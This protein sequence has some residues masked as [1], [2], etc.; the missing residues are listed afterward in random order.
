MKFNSPKVCNII[1]SDGSIAIQ[2]FTPS[3]FTSLTNGRSIFTSC[4]VWHNAWDSQRLQGDATTESQEK[5]A[6]WSGLDGEVLACFG[7]L[8][9][10]LTATSN[11]CQVILHP[12]YTHPYTAS[13][14]AV[15]APYLPALIAAHRQAGVSV[16]ESIIV[17]S[18]STSDREDGQ[19]IPYSR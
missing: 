10:L 14:D 11:Q 17:T 18:L 3:G 6:L 1:P 2:L 8:L 19:C 5:V 7:L 9:P 13:S 16:S 4:L 12:L 15:T